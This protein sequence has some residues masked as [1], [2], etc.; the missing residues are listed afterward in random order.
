MLNIVK[1]RPAGAVVKTEKLE[2]DG[3]ILL[4]DVTHWLPPTDL[5]SLSNSL[6]GRRTAAVT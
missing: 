4:R 3:T 1:T 2:P 5:A 6:P